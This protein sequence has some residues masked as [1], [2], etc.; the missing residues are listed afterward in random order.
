MVVG[1]GINVNWPAELPDELADVAVALNHVTGREVDREDLLVALLRQLDRPL[2]A[3]RR[4]PGRG[5]ARWPSWRTRSA[6]LG[7]RVR[8]DLGQDELVGHRRRR[9]PEGHLVVETLEGERR[10]VAVGDVVHLRTCLIALR[11]F[12]QAWTTSAIDCGL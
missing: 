9:H 4:Q 12:I 10:T 1:I 3:A 5:A 11:A 8:V 7:R 2:R 6:T